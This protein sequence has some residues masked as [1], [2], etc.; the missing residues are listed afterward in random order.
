MACRRP[1]DD[2]NG[3]GHFDNEFLKF[4]L[5]LVREAR[6]AFEAAV[7]S[8]WLTWWTCSMVLGVPASWL[9]KTHWLH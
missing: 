6:F 4:V 1:D 9:I 2:P 5:Y 3:F 8:K 7:A